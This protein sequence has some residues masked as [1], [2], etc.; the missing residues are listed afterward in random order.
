MIGGS[1]VLANLLYIGD[2][3]GFYAHAW[4]YGVRALIR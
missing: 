4:Q 1:V 2:D 3:V